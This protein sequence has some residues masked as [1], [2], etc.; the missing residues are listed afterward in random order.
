ML[1]CLTKDTEWGEVWCGS[2]YPDRFDETYE[3]EKATCVDCL[4]ALRRA[5]KAAHY[6]LV[7]LTTSSQ[8]T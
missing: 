6:R 1:V 5:G 7:E 4:H 8:E 2:R 3:I